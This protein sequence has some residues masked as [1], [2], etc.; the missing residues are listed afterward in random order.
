MATCIYLYL[1][2]FYLFQLISFNHFQLLASSLWPLWF[3][4]FIFYTVLHSGYTVFH[5]VSM[6]NAPAT[7]ILKHLTIRGVTIYIHLYLF[8]S[9]YILFIFLAS[10]LWLLTSGFRLLTSGQKY[11]QIMQPNPKVEI[12]PKKL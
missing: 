1:L 8:I 5:R 7:T 10:G 3:S 2:Y 12:R 6:P 4:V 9:T 11:H